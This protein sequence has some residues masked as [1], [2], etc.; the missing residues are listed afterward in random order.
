MAREK[1]TVE[2]ILLIILCAIAYTL[3]FG[4]AFVIIHY[5]IENSLK[6]LLQEIKWKPNLDE[7]NYY[8]YKAK[9]EFIDAL[10]KIPIPELHV[11]STN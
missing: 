10:D 9:Q 1:F 8:A 6:Y 4:V 7:L 11:N 3:P 5:S 2:K